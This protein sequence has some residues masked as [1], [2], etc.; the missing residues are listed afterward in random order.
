MNNLPSLEIDIPPEVV[1]KVI[2]ALKDLPIPQ[3]DADQMHQLMGIPIG[4]FVDK[5][6]LNHK[7]LVDV[8]NGDEESPWHLRLRVG[9][10]L[11]R[12]VI[13]LFESK[14]PAYVLL[15]AEGSEIFLETAQ[16]PGESHV[17]GR[18]ARWMDAE[19]ALRNLPDAKRTVGDQIKIGTTDLALAGLRLVLTSMGA[20][21][22]TQQR[23]QLEAVI[24]RVRHLP[25]PE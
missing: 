8:H 4:A 24:E 17:T 9:F 10:G 21:D 22:F 5:S 23:N 16:F 14:Q 20:W 6:L 1:D 19:S 7:P 12:V 15:D 2:L 13:L 11:D 25:S 18:F 3:L